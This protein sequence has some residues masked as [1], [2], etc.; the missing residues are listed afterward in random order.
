DNSYAAL[1]MYVTPLISDITVTSDIDS[2]TFKSNFISY[3]NAK[4]E[5][6]QLIVKKVKENLD[7]L[8]NN[9]VNLIV[10][11]TDNLHTYPSGLI[12]VKQSDNFWRLGLN[13]TDEIL[14]DKTTNIIEGKQY[15]ESFLFKT[16][17]I[18]NSFSITFFTNNGHHPIQAS[19]QDRG[20]G[21]FK[22][23]A[24]YTTQVGDQYIRALDINNINITNGTY[25]DILNPKLEKGNKATDWT[26]APE[27]TQKKIDDNY[28]DY[29][30]F[31]NTI[32]NNDK[33]AMQKS[34]EDA[35]TTINSALGG[36]VLKRN[37][38]LLIM[39]NNDVNAAQKIWRWNVNGLGYSST[40]YNGPYATAIT[41][42]GKINA[43]FVTTGTLDAN[44][45]KTGVLSSQDDSLKFDL[46]GGSMKT[47]DNQG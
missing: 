27:D 14:Q 29:K 28:N 25:I 38:E 34:I 45:I 33:S 21:V 3:Y 20:N 13:S 17:G 30:N 35:T 12:G 32:Y 2:N 10:G 7:E 47:S 31:I 5:L 40:G 37:S 9:G 22:A 41:K 11:S 39:V 36:Y 8:E 26:P 16:D 42:D 1:E 24:T 19:I 6:L 4:N 18:F 23:Y 44:V 43:D 15:T 46:T